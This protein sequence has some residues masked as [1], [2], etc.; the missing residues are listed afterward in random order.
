MGLLRRRALSTHREPR[1]N[2]RS[3]KQIKRIFML[4]KHNR[5]VLLGLI[6]LLPVSAK[7]DGEIE[8]DLV[9]PVMTDEEP[10]A[11]K[12]VRRVAP[13]YKGTMSITRCICPSIGNRAATIR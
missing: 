7:G 1:K 5:L 10:A 2:L 6:S 11:G 3:R 8:K 9:T 12:R 4:K 13:E